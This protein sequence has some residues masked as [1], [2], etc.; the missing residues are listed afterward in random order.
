[1]KG[2]GVVHCLG[3]FGES[4]VLGAPLV[5]LSFVLGGFFLGVFCCLE[6]GMLL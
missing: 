3:C 5:R 6:L 4:S 2:G 1:M